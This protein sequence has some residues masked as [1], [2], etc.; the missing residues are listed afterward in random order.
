MRRKAPA[1]IAVLLSLGAATAMAQ[2]GAGIGTGT[3]QG[4]GGGMGLSTGWVVSQE[5][6]P[7]FALMT[8]EERIAHREKVRSMKNYEECKTYMDDHQNKMEARAKERGSA[9]QVIRADPCE[10]M[11]AKVIAQ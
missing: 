4:M 1:L 6:T 3:R 7:G 2:L 9:L 5:S 8:A 11:K 10:N